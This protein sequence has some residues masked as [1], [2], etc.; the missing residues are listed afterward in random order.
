MY[1]N[2]LISLVLLLGYTHA[3]ADQK[4]DLLTQQF[5]D[6]LSFSV[7]GKPDYHTLRQLCLPTCILV[8]TTQQLD[9]FTLNAYCEQFNKK[10][11]QERIT[12][13]VE[14]ELDATTQVWGTIA[15]RASRYT[16]SITCGST[17]DTTDGINSIQF[18]LSDNSWHIASIIWTDTK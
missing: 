11:E 6:A 15:H 5:Y 2:Y 8:R 13:F 1:N 16:K 4:L 10:I 12:A 18:V 17:T 9:T 7:N 14:H 3:Y